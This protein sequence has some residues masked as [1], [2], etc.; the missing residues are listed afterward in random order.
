[1]PIS[2]RG[3]DG[4]R[5]AGAVRKDVEVVARRGAAREHQLGHRRQRRDLD[6]LRREPR[7]ERVERVSQPNSSASCAAGTA[8]VSVWN[9]W[10][11]VLT[12]PGSTTW[13]GKID[14]LVGDVRQVLV[15][16]RPRSGC[17]RRRGRRPRSRAAPSSMV[18]RMSAFLASSVLGLIARP[19]PLPSSAP[20]ARRSSHAIAVPAVTAGNRRAAA[21][22]RRAGGHGRRP[23]GTPTVGGTG[24][25]ACASAIAAMRAARSG[26]NGAERPAFM[27]TWTRICSAVARRLAGLFM[28]HGM[29]DVHALGIMGEN[30]EVK[31]R[32]SPMRASR[33]LWMRVSSV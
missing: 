12:R 4:C 31:A 11:W 3:L 28:G 24:R 16:R 33:R 29:E 30:A 26:G 2:P 6:H 25:T 15:G 20:V 32:G 8:R 19:V 23:R 14:D 10:W 1:M 17:P 5:R 9:M 22:N 18:T 21:G 27:S 13:P 7:P